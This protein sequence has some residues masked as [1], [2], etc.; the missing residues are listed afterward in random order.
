[1]EKGPVGPR[2][3]KERDEN[4][5]RAGRAVLTRG[6]TGYRV[7]SGAFGELDEEGRT[8]GAPGMHADLPRSDDA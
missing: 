1:M 7:G 5:A 4:P 3:S 2:G 8:R 6:M